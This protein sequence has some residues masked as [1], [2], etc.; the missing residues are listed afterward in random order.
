MTNLTRSYPLACYLLDY[1]RVSTG[2]LARKGL[3]TGKAILFI[4]PAVL[5]KHKTIK[6]YLNTIVEKA[7]ETHLSHFF[8]KVI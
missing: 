5:Y 8:Q 3:L 6:S 2:F 1:I 7:G 4:S